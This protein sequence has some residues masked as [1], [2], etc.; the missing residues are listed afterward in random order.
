[1]C[2]ASTVIQF[3]MT[4]EKLPINFVLHAVTIILLL[5]IYMYTVLQQLRYSKVTYG[6]L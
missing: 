4:D 5:F 3:K 1:M 6:K 2:C